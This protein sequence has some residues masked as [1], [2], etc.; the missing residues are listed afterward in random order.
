MARYYSV[1]LAINVFIGLFY[2]Y[3]RKNSGISPKIFILISVV[4]VFTGMAFPVILG[5]SSL[6]M[7]VAANI[8]LIGIG[9]YYITG[10]ISSKKSEP[11][12]VINTPVTDESALYELVIEQP[13]EEAP[14][15]G[16]LA[17]AEFQGQETTVEEDYIE[18]EPVV[19]ETVAEE[20]TEEEPVAEETVDEES[21]E[22]TAVTEESIEEESIE[23]AA[24][25]AEEAV[26]EEPTEEGAVTEES[27]E[28]SIEE[29][30]IAAEVAAGEDYT[31]EEPV[32]EEESVEEAA[33]EPPL[34]WGVETFNDIQGVENMSVVNNLRIEDP[35]E[36]RDSYIMRGFD[37]KAEGKLELSVKYFSSAMELNP[38]SD[39]EFMLIVDICAM[40]QELG[41]YQR[42]QENLKQFRNDRPNLSEEVLHEIIILQKTLEIFLETLTK[43]NT[44]NMPFSKVPALIRVS[45]EEKV[46]QWKNEVF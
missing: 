7:T 20:S 22:E 12:V 30:A 21:I 46:N 35:F 17:A 15:E 14:V 37:A 36:L 32:V 10:L 45:V 13:V 40:L 43:A 24:I 34:S 42:A 8:L 38:P 6:I 27:I 9:A 16:E 18:E 28:E 41:Q 11:D 19:E 1:I 44:P 4:S 25:A 39:L 2:F 23:E 3:I 31:E 29:V 26:E 33:E 5:N